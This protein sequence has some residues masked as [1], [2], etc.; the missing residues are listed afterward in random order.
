MTLNEIRICTL[1]HLIHILYSSLTLVLA[2]CEGSHISSQ[3]KFSSFLTL[4]IVPHTPKASGICEKKFKDFLWKIYERKMKNPWKSCHPF[5][6]V[7][8]VYGMQNNRLDL[9]VILAEKNSKKNHCSQRYLRNKWRKMIKE[10]Q[11]S[12]DTVQF[13]DIFFSK[14][15]REIEPV[16]LHTI[17]PMNPTK[18]VTAISW[19]F[20]FLLIDFSEKIFEFFF[21]N[22]W[23]LGDMWNYVQ[24]RKKKKTFLG[25]EMACF[26]EC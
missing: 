9:T 22:A 17:N 4:Y 10:V 16:V 20:H 26:A 18:W 8:R 13:F 21:T 1:Y 25:G 3:N 6:W 14:S 5:W 19:I 12:L 23:C 11:I 24:G 2:F 7:H 15:D